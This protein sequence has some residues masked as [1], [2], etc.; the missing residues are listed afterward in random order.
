ML[1]L[2]FET[3]PPP[4]HPD[5]EVCVWRDEQ[6]QVF[7]RA[8]AQGAR[9]WIDWPGL[10]VFAFAAGSHQVGVWPAAIDPEIVAGAFA[11]RL[12]PIILQALGRQALHA[13]AVMGTGGVLA[14]CGVGHSGKSTLSFALARVGYRQIADDALVLERAESAVQARL[15][16]FE[17]GL[18]EPSRRHFHAATDARH[19]SLIDPPA[20]PTSVP[21]RGV[22]VL[23]Q[24]ISLRSPHGPDSVP[25]VQAF[26]ALVTHARCFDEADRGHTR[27]LVEDYLAIAETVPVFALRYPPQF[28]QLSAL[29]TRVSELCR[30]LG[31][32][33]VNIGR[34]L[35]AIP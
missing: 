33:P 17:P 5:R 30:T 27:Q 34:P 7:A 11:R 26:A 16:P 21:L 13:S 19:S 3:Q 10:G 24:D 22:V 2:V 9:R 20:L 6:G 28:E 18:R 35:V 23:Q 1:D 8:F 4:R 12:Q 31:V 32:S 15:L 25:P 14:F 29:V